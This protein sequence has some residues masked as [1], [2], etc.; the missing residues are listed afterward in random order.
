MI[1]VKRARDISP[2]RHFRLVGHNTGG[3]FRRVGP[4]VRG[5]RA[6][7]AWL[8]IAGLR[9]AAGTGR[10]NA[11]ERCSLH[12]A[13]GRAAEVVSRGGW[14]GFICFFRD[15]STLRDQRASRLVQFAT[16]VTAQ[17]TSL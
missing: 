17:R 14:R 12:D 1:C 5:G 16:L 7:D 8:P 11:N 2:P 3:G 13:V 9:K 6:R 4:G 10:V 15:S